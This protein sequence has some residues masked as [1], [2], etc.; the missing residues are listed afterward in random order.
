MPQNASL[1][2]R[3]SSNYSLTTKRFL[4]SRKGIKRDTRK[5]REP[6]NERFESMQNHDEQVATS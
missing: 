5:R 2:L 4:F 6:L 3:D 1:A